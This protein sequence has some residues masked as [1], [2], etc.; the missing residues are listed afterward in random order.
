M[1]IIE[2]YHDWKTIR[3]LLSPVNLGERD[4]VGGGAGVA[5]EMDVP[6][7]VV[8]GGHDHDTRVVHPL[9]RLPL[10]ARKI[11]QVLLSS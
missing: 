7:E 10:S 4:L 11:P 8:G 1:T 6:A 5:V 2:K 9:S 3:G